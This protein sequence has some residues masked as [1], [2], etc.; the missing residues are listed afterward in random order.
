VTATA[1]SPSTAHRLEELWEDRPGLLGFLSTVDHKRIG[2]RYF[3]TSLVFLALGGVQA[4]LMRTQLAT[5]ENT[6]LDPGTYN[7]LMTMHGVTMIFLFNTPIWAGFGNYV[8]PLQIGTRD[9]AFPRMNALSYWIFLFSGL[10]IYSS[11]LVA[12]MPEGGWFAYPSLTE[13]EYLPGLGIDFWAVG[14]AF[15]G[16]ST[17]VGA[18]NFIVTTFKLRAPG[19]TPSRLPIFVW[20]ILVMSFMIL[21]ALPAVTLAQVL[22]ELDRLFDF[23]FFVAGAGGD[24]VL[25]QHLF[26]LWGHPEVY[27]VFVPAT[28]VVSTVVATFS[29]TRLAGHLLVVTALVAIGFLSFGVWVHHMFTVGLGFLALSFF[30]AASFMV[31]IP[32]GVQFFAWIATL[33]NG[34][35]KFQVPLLWALGMMFIFLLGGI[36]G[37]M[38]AMVPFDFQAQDSYFVVA[39]FHYTLIGGS[40]F[41]VFAA[42]Y[43][44]FP[45]I[46][47]RMPN[48]RVGRWAFWITFVAFNLTFFPMHVLGLW[49]M[50][51]RYYT[52]LSDLGWGPLN[53]LATASAYLLFT[54]FALAVL[55]LVWSARR[56]RPAGPDPWHADSL[57]WATSSPPPEYNFLEIPRVHSRY[58]LWDQP[59]ATVGAEEEPRHDRPV[60]LPP[61]GDEEHLTL[62]TAGV[63][64]AAERVIP[65]P[66]PTP[67]PFLLTVSVAVTFTGVLVRSLGVA[68]VGV[69]LVIGAIAGWMWPD[70]EDEPLELAGEDLEE[71]AR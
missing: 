57:E 65:M 35:P 9:M 20:S 32:S 69:L 62:S 15:L 31:S 47:G 34:R 21:F 19:M 3:V 16:I 55:N 68:I 13:Q 53:L 1:A 29:R 63:D 36:T 26:W 2:R 64:A 25:Y 37:V 7:R 70:W 43:Y 28:G 6:F 60:L 58:P 54:G 39:H 61:E 40:V 56:G 30:A 67:W 18:V 38:V 50:P 5:P 23:N 11:F 41:P 52:Y 51:R 66:H 27:I 45:K 4:M 46:T 12:Q 49:G 17:T 59:V 48:L 14:L 10:F 33:W 22:L 24:P 71:A 42:L 8:L 44:W